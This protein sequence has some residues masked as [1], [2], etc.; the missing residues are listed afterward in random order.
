MEKTVKLPSRS[1]RLTWEPNEN[2]P[3]PPVNSMRATW[4]NYASPSFWSWYITEP[5]IS[6]IT[7]RYYINRLLLP[8]RSKD[9]FQPPEKWTL[10]FLQRFHKWPPVSPHEKRIPGP[11]LTEWNILASLNM[12]GSKPRLGKLALPFLLLPIGKESQLD[13]P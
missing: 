12:K 3:A 5:I 8:I 1:P 10:I 9:F 11:L 4:A 2:Q 7:L 13:C 6:K